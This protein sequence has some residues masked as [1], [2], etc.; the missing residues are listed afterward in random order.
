MVTKWSPINGPSNVGQCRLGYMMN[1]KKDR[2]GKNNGNAKGNRHRRKGRKTK[3]Q[4][5]VILPGRGVLLWPGLMPFL[6]SLPVEV[7]SCHLLF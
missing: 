6:D 2:K 3:D 5:F 4:K 1:N 7:L